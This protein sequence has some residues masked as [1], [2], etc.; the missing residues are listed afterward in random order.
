MRLIMRV[1]TVATISVFAMAIGLVG[2][3]PAEPAAAG[4]PADPGDLVIEAPEPGAEAAEAHEE[5][6][7]T[8]EPIEVVGERTESEQMFA[9]PDGTFTSEINMAPVRVEQGG[10]WVPVD[11]TLQVRPDGTVAPKAVPMTMT[12]SGGGTVPLVR[13]DDDGKQLLLSWPTTLP[14]PQLVGDTA[15]FPEVLPGVDLRM[16]A[17]S[18]GFSKVLVVKTRQAAANPALATIGLGLTTNGLS[19]VADEA[20]NL[21]ITDDAGE[22]VFGAS[23]PVMWD[24]TPTEDA[25]TGGMPGPDRPG[26][27]QSVA[28]VTVGP[29]RLEL[30]PDQALLSDPATQYPV[31]IDPSFTGGS[32][33]WTLVKEGVSQSKWNGANDTQPILGKSGFSTWDGPAVKYR[34]YFQFNTRQAL[35]TALLSAQFR[36]MEVWAPSCS[37]RVVQAYGTAPIGRGTNWANQP[38]QQWAVGIGEHNVAYGYPGCATARFLEWNATAAVRE[39][40]NR[41]LATTTIMLK[42]G[43]ETDIFAWKKWLVNADSPKLTVNYNR[44]PDRPFELS[45]EH[46]SCSTVPNQPYV[47]PLN[48]SDQPLGPTL[49]A[50][51]SDPDG[52]LVRAR[53]Q[54]SMLDGSRLATVDSAAAA[55]RSLFGVQVP[56]GTFRDGETFRYRVV[57]LD[58]THSGPWTGYCHVTIDRTRPPAPQAVSSATYPKDDLG[59]AA[60]Q[61]GV[62]TLTAPPGSDVVGFLYDLHDQPTRFVRTN[63]PGGTASVLVTPPANGPQTLYVYSVDRANNLSNTRYEYHFAAGRGTPPAA[64]WRLDGLSTTQVVDSQPQRHD[65]TVALGPARW[66][67]GRHGDSLLLDG[68]SGHVNTTNGRTVGTDVAFSAAAW[69]KLDQAGTTNQVVVSQDAT[70]PSAFTLQYAGDVKK[71][72]F[73]MAQSDAANVASDRVVSNAV[74]RVGVWTHLVGTYEPGSGEMR[75]YVDGVPQSTAGRHTSRWTHPTGTVQIGRGKVNGGYTGYLRGAIDDVQVYQRMIA[76]VEA[77]ELA[78]VPVEELFL[79][80]DE[81]QGTTATDVSG[82]LRSAQLGTAAAWTAGADIIGT[83]SAVRLDGTA[84]GVLTTTKPGVRTDQSFM[85]SAQVMLD[86]AAASGTGTMTAVGQDG[87][88]SSGFTLGYNQATKGWMFAVSAA[89]AASPSRLV[90]DSSALGR[91]ATPGVWTHLIGIYDAAKGQLRLFVDG[92]PADSRLGRTTANVGGGVVLGR[93]KRNGQPGGFWRGSIDDV[94]VWSGVN[95]AEPLSTWLFPVSDRPSVFDGQ[96][97]RYLTAN[98]ANSDHVSASGGATPAH[99]FEGS[100]GLFAPEGA[101]N[102]QML[103]MCWAGNEFTSPDPGC[104]GR[105]V[106]GPMG[107]VYLVPPPGQPVVAVYRC[108]VVTASY[109]DHFESTDPKCEGQ[110]VDGPLGYTLPYMRLIR[111]DSPTFPNDHTSSTFGVSADYRPEGALGLLAMQDGPGRTALW[112]CQMGRDTFLSTDAGCEGQTVVGWLGQIWTAPP[113]EFASL[114]LLRCRTAAGELFESTNPGCE[115]Q[116]LVG[117]L[118]YVVTHL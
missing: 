78:S 2:A 118:G 66:V 63:K 28:G 20:G 19:V 76:E 29:D 58:P 113:A 1:R 93:D 71:W 91:L 57:G 70:Q 74:A 61:T 8:G 53:F 34:T 117:S 26:A 105:E 33:G 87:P 69:V 47:N 30:R 9:N 27:R 35:G 100:L 107:R 97:N 86:P 22:V 37:A 17:T 32:A 54:W 39:S 108:Q 25:E 43:S 84:A 77:Y 81:G 14:T 3:V 85:V 15:V 62:F 80:L 4:L 6:V 104:E 45:A 114:E 24:S 60:G 16:Q 49:R 72:A 115:G 116:T 90:V 18:V 112:R 13:I 82:Y 106:L 12:F 10:G 103:Y 48:P 5:A 40:M 56:S 111:Y 88:L 94:H 98:P 44:F 55:S 65:G 67:A 101:E 51:V 96:L 92:E 31:Y 95:E 68:A 7:A 83:G 75:L 23:A 38:S 46:K 109:F 110:T 36:V 42:A 79:P 99:H 52:G 11:T 21:S 59:G 64:H 41:G 102:T 89:D 50:R 73:T